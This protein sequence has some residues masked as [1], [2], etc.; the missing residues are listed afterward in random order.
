MT[1]LI[2]GAQGFIG[3]HVVER[4]GERPLSLLV[5]RAG[6]DA[7]EVIGDLRDADSLRRACAGIDT[8]IHCAG[9]AHAF[10]DVDARQAQQHRAVNFEGTLALG[11]AAAAAGVRRFV[12]LSS[13][14]AMGEPGGQCVDES[15]PAP[16]ASDY[17]RAK[18][19]AEDALSAIGAEQGMAVMQLRLAMVYGPGG[20]GNLERMIGLVRRGVFPPLPETGN[21]RSLVYVADVVEAIVRAAEGRLAEGAYIVADPQTYSGRQLYDAIRE[22]LGLPRRVWAVPYGLLR[23]GARM[24]DMAGR[25]RGRPLPLNSEALDKLLGSACYLPT[26]LVGQGWCAH[27]SLRDGLRSCVAARGDHREAAS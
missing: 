4:L 3:R 5:R 26:R 12:H 17:G 24:G 2:T 13:V 8:V 14:K 22:A 10:H 27:T 20:R 18:R 7:R 11:R 25:W 15:W 6:G 23:A 19:D 9:Y 16:P 21:V 1:W